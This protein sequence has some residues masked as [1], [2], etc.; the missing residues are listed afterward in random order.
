MEP[1]ELALRI[2][3]LGLSL[4]LL[5]IGAQAYRRAGGRRMMW[6]LVAF[7]GFAV[8][9]TAALMGEVYGDH[10]WTVPNNLVLLL[11]LI[12]SANYLALLK[13]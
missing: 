9:A 6:V 7:L 1:W 5:L 3:L 8:L 13:D 12:I 2:I 11:L 10:N 4:I